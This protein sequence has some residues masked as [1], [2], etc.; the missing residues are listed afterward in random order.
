VNA[1]NKDDTGQLDGSNLSVTNRRETSE[2]LV[3]D[4]E[5][6]TIY[7]DVKTALKNGQFNKPLREKIRKLD[8][9]I[10]GE[11]S[12]LATSD[13][14][15][16]L[17]IKCML[18]E[19]HDYF[20]AIGSSD[21]LLG[22]GSI[23]F[24]ELKLI[25]DVKPEDRKII[26]EQI[27]FCLNHAHAF[28]Y[29]PY[30]YPEAK[31]R[32]SWCLD[33]IKSKLRDEE[34]FPCYGTLAQAELYLGQI[35]RRMNQYDEAE[36]CFGRA[37]GYYYERARRRM[38][39]YDYERAKR[40]TGEYRDDESHR[41][42]LLSELTLSK[43]RSAICLGSGIGRVNF[44]RGH[45]KEAIHNILSARVLLLG[46]EAEL[47]TANLDLLFASVKRSIGG[48]KDKKGLLE[49]IK[50]IEDAYLVFREH[51]HVPYI[52]NAAI[53]LSL[54][55]LYNGEHK[56]ALSKLTELES[57]LDE[58]DKSKWKCPRLLVLS[59]I[60]RERG[61]PMEAER[62]ASEALDH[63]A[64][65]TKQV[66]YQIEALIVR[67]EAR[68]LLRE[69]DEARKDLREALELNEYGKKQANIKVEAV[70]QLHLA[71]SFAL[72]HDGR[73]AK[74]CFARWKQLE[75]KVEHGI[76]H[77]LAA[78]VEKDIRGLSKDF[79]IPADAESL[80]YNEHL[81]ELQKFLVNQAKQR[82]QTIQ[83]TTEKLKIS[84]QTLHQWQEKKRMI[85]DS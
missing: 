20:G 42:A 65:H 30:K 57:I 46:T 51:D 53:E 73:E 26:R 22:E 39:E 69:I 79:V 58:D 11:G 85:A 71:R 50:N 63:A 56:K 68:I 9:F 10:N 38:A 1:S 44:S 8:N 60:S 14:L 40:S 82:T 4:N 83:E 66:P 81:K 15:L 49:A 23:I 64:E 67:S 18:A 62:L 21:K 52:A 31:K 6:S 70:C 3:I 34:V 84:R 76:I 13:K 43:Y 17:K 25:E 54:A 72:E 2:I 77:E 5:F 48:R 29:R 78:E 27:I 61:N 45:L 19:A 80:N 33:F 12:S 74:H 35:H 55:Y 24:D 32:T 47:H 37:I 16:Y 59:R 75:K 28:L 36:E 41:E 7:R